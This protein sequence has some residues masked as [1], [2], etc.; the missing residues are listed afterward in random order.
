MLS[1]IIQIR[2][3][4]AGNIQPFGTVVL[5]YFAY[6]SIFVLLNLQAI[7]TD[8]AFVFARSPTSCFIV[9]DASYTGGLKIIFPIYKRRW[10]KHQWK[11][12]YL[13]NYFSFFLN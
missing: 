3:F 5:I 1:F 10:E 2:T 4:S 11:L 9:S 6:F 8:A 7:Q 13:Q 12:N